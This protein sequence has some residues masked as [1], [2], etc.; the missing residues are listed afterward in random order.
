MAFENS[1]S[2][3]AERFLNTDSIH[4]Y[5]QRTHPLT[6]CLIHP[7]HPRTSA[8]GLQVGRGP[9][10]VPYLCHPFLRLRLALAA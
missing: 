1:R 9:Q 8:D 4:T 6:L 2:E 7:S 10:N 5:L 3:R